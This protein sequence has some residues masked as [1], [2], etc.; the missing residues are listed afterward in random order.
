MTKKVKYYLDETDQIEVDGHTLS[1][2]YLANVSIN[3]KYMSSYAVYGKDNYYCEMG[4]YVESLDNLSDEPDSIYQ[5][6]NIAWVDAKSKVYGASKIQFG[7]QVDNSTILNSDVHC[8]SLVCDSVISNS[9]V[10]MVINSEIYNS[11]CQETV[12]KSTIRNSEVEN[13]TINSTITD[14]TITNIKYSMIINANLN[15]VEYYG[16]LSGTFSNVDED[17]IE[18]YQLSYRNQ[19]DEK[20]NMNLLVGPSSIAVMQLKQNKINF[21][22]G[23]VIPVGDISLEE[24]SS[25]LNEIVDEQP[26]GGKKALKLLDKLSEREV[27]TDSDLDFGDTLER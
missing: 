19:F 7:A 3:K 22:N 16:S 20:E 27:L 13:Y 17:D 24:L 15:N 1:R 10:K 21:V 6:G 5:S 18:R 23:K 8:D 11:C 25:V 2:L 9:K 26:I 12:E 14:S 4:G